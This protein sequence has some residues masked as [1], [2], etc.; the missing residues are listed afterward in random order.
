MPR[1]FVA[2]AAPKYFA[3]T[4]RTSVAAIESPIMFG[5]RVTPFPDPACIEVALVPTEI[6]KLSIFPPSSSMIAN[7]VSWPLLCPPAGAKRS[8]SK[9]AIVGSVL[10]VIVVSAESLPAEFA[11]NA[12]KK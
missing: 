1:V 9:V 2:V 3:P 8:V 4:S 5:N 7:K 11:A 12:L 10:N 6:S